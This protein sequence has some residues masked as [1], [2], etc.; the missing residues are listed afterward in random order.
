MTSRRTDGPREAVI[1]ICTLRQVDAKSPE[2]QLCDNLAMI[3][4]MAEAARERGWRLDVAVI[5]E[6]SFKFAESDLRAA[7]EDPDGKTARAIGEKARQHGAYVTA[8][9]LRREG[10]EVRNSVVLLDRSGRPLGFYDKVHPALME[11]DSLE[12]GV[13][14]GRDFP[15]FDLDFGR[16]GMQIC[17][18]VSWEMGWEA[19]GNQDAELVLFPT[20]PAVPLALRSH[21][22][23]NGYFIAASTVHPPA[24]I[25]DPVGRVLVST[26]A[27]REVAVVQVNL[28]YRV[29]SSPCMWSWQ[30]A[31]HPEYHGR[32]RVEWDVDSHQ[33]LVSS[34][35]SGLPVH[36]FLRTE[37]LSTARRRKTHHE[38]LLR[39]AWGVEPAAPP[40]AARD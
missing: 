16:V 3:D 35:E 4:A 18:D 10:D 7:A 40:A 13:T 1:G 20:N 9:I 21:A 27:N 14:P 12:F 37:G 6:V 39:K 26:T 29:L 34:Q 38:E 17:V 19:L 11:D 5:P 31:D 24:V 15:V 25:V 22:W 28:D 30:I 33:Y 32:I 23:R 8:P 2:E 36:R